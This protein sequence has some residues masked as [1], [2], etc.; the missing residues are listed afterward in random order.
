MMHDEGRLLWAGGGWGRVLA[1]RRGLPTRRPDPK[2]QWAGPRSLRALT[3]AW[4]GL[5]AQGCPEPGS[6]SAG[7]WGEQSPE[8]ASPSDLRAGAARLESDVPAREKAARSPRACEV[9]RSLC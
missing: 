9:G 4:L 1:H 8:A 5:R 6:R 2:E 3:R 7:R